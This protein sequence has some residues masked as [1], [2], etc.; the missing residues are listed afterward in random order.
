MI[1]DQYY[2]KYYFCFHCICKCYIHRFGITT[3]SYA[4]KEVPIT[5]TLNKTN[6][7][8]IKKVNKEI[9]SKK[10]INA[11]FLHSDRAANNRIGE[12]LAEYKNWGASNKFEA[13]KGG[14]PV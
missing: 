1:Y 7:S 9:Q 2:W 8:N 4:N 6:L 14:S 12:Y 5:F 3:N 11:K 13:E 10:S